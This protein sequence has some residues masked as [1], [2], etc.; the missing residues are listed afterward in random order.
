[1]KLTLILTGHY[2][3][4]ETIKKIWSEE[5]SK[6]HVELDVVFLE[7]KNGQNL[8]KQLD[9]KSF[10]ALISGTK[11]IAVGRPDKHDAERIIADLVNL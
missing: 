3:S 8:A 5:C 6:H 7:A 1:M 2:S 11:V 10:P 9:L 4:C